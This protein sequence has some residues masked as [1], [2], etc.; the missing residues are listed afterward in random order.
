MKKILVSFATLAVIS[1][2]IMTTTAWVK[3]KQHIQT[4][5]PDHELGRDNSYSN[6]DFGNFQSVMHPFSFQKLDP[7]IADVNV[8]AFGQSDSWDLYNDIANYLDQRLAN[9]YS[10]F[11]IASSTLEDN[12]NENSL[13]TNFAI[14]DQ[15]TGKEWISP[16]LQSGQY[17]CY[18]LELINLLSH[19]SFNFSLNYSNFDL[20]KI[21]KPINAVPNVNHGTYSIPDNS[22][23]GYSGFF[24]W[25][26]S[27]PYTTFNLS[28]YLVNVNTNV[29]WPIQTSK[30]YYDY[31]LKIDNYFLNPI[32]WKWNSYMDILYDDWYHESNEG[33]IPPPP[34]PKPDHH[35]RTSTL[36]DNS[37]QGGYSSQINYQI[38]QNSTD[39]Y[40]LVKPVSPPLKGGGA[41]PRKW[42]A[43][44]LAQNNIHGGGASGNNGRLDEYGDSGWASTAEMY[45]TWNMNGQSLNEETSW[46]HNAQDM[47]YI[48]QFWSGTS[49]NEINLAPFIAGYSNVADWPAEQYNWQLEWNFTTTE[50]DTS[51]KDIF[52]QTSAY[53]VTGLEDYS[54]FMTYKD[55]NKV[56]KNYAEDYGINEINYLYGSAQTVT[57]NLNYVASANISNTT[58]LGQPI[59]LDKPYTIDEEGQNV[60]DVHLKDPKIAEEYQG[61][62]DQLGDIEFHIDIQ[63]NYDFSQ[64]VDA[65]TLEKTK[66]VNA[67]GNPI[68]ALDIDI[69]GTEAKQF[70]Q[71]ISKKGAA[72]GEDDVLSVLN[73]KAYLKPNLWKDALSPGYDLKTSIYDDALKIDSNET[74]SLYDYISGGGTTTTPDESILNYEDGNRGAFRTDLCGDIRDANSY[75]DH[76]KTNGMTLRFLISLR[77]DTLTWNC[78]NFKKPKYTPKKST[79]AYD[80]MVLPQLQYPTKDKKP[81]SPSRQLTAQDIA[82]KLQGKTI[83]L[84]PRFW[85]GK[86]IK[87]YKE[88]LDNAI[89]QQGIL[90]KEEVQYVSWG[91][92][93]LNQARSYPN[94]DFTVSKDGETALAHNITLDPL[95]DEQIFNKINNLIE[96]Y[97]I[98]EMKGEI[99][100]DRGIFGDPPYQDYINTSISEQMQDTI[101]S[102]ADEIARVGGGTTLDNDYG[103]YI[104]FDKM[105]IYQHQNVTM[106]VKVGNYTKDYQVT[107][108]WRIVDYLKL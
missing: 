88:Q 40:G 94:C 82:N 32:T 98:G 108:Y 38:D 37:D 45:N 64:G 68:Y 49:N 19:T 47:L 14:V 89:V 103:K 20:S 75:N 48:D 100:Y 11:G 7:T 54:T 51:Y 28:S 33:I 60:I 65:S 69:R 13:G 70:E 91:D 79:N 30:K 101:D 85:V 63:N 90:T 44:T 39:H 26:S 34:W 2:S 46:G 58:G 104:S 12:I 66:Q 61:D 35:Y 18:N 25:N 52:S 15:N 80:A 4:K 24:P 86:D 105:K 73:N 29:T 6:L 8:N 56:L 59:P 84:D 5:D 83:I 43:N 102:V 97:I 78:A 23:G 10:Q 16:S 74:K 22:D 76:L 95:G 106:H 107:F 99:E 1:S 71:K 57:F 81:L 50:M 87:N 93:T 42:Q 92:L 27:Q 55:P 53:Q 17:E 41:W 36:N 31:L 77:K 3:N 62:Y 72:Y 9:Y 67:D 96:K 21:I